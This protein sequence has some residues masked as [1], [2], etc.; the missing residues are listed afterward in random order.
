[1]AAQ[2]AVSV[3]MLVQAEIAASIAVKEAMLRDAGLLRSISEA[4]MQI[5]EAFRAG[6]R[7]LLLGN[8]GS[9]ADA[10][11]IAAEFV[12]RYRMERRALPALA[13]TVN[14]S[15]LTAIGNDYGFENVFVRQVEAFARSGD[16]LIGISTSGNSSNVVRAML[17]ANAMQVKTI[18]MTGASGG[19]LKD[20]AELC[21]CMPSSHPARIQEAHILTGHAIAA[22]VERELF[23]GA[24]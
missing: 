13:L 22:V 23:A 5:A 9:A 11:H 21:L 20:S 16:V 17:L 3:E 8:G 18:A 2:A 4:A 7:L 15:S 19:T 24:A 14:T 1:M 12:G 10:Q 6:R